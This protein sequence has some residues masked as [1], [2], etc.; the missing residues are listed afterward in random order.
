[1]DVDTSYLGS[2]NMVIDEDTQMHDLV[3]A[4]GNIIT[5]SR[6][7][8]LFVYTIIGDPEFDDD[9]MSPTY[10]CSV[11][12][13]LNIGK[14]GRRHKV[15]IYS[16]YLEFMILVTRASVAGRLPTVIIRDRTTPMIGGVNAWEDPTLRKRVCMTV[17]HD[18]MLMIAE[19]IKTYGSATC[20]YAIQYREKFTARSAH[21][22]AQAM[23]HLA[24]SMITQGEIIGVH[25]RME[26]VSTTVLASSP[27]LFFQL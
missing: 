18:A 6:S 5:V 13:E 3:T 14:V 19:I 17:L 9:S 2:S 22:Y 25:T 26:P 16:S 23:I 7:T 11:M 4:V 21:T 15:D 10:G 24:C 8:G 20:A 12:F 27:S 1:M